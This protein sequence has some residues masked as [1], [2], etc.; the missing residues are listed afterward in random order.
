MENNG[1]WIE[2]GLQRGWGD[3]CIFAADNKVVSNING[4]VSGLRKYA[5]V[6]SDN[7]LRI[8]VATENVRNSDFLV[9]YIFKGEHAVIV[10]RHVYTVP[11]VIPEFSLKYP[12]LH[13]DKLSKKLA[14]FGFIKVSSM[15]I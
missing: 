8:E 7:Q 12:I 3:D 4:T 15:L 9:L 1:L 11:N 5:I 2:L 10:E 6:S 14:T 13:M